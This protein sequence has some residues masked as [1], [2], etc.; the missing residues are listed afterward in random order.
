MEMDTAASFEHEALRFVLDQDSLQN[1]AQLAA[2]KWQVGP[3]QVIEAAKR[4]AEAG[5]V[6]L[7]R[8]GGTDVDPAEL[9]P[10]DLDSE[11]PIWLEPTES[12][13]PQLN[14]IVAAVR[15]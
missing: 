7:Y 11:T 9:R 3:E 5:L 4:M 6:R 12:T 2:G 8:E 1:L 15:P 14:K 13:I 10:A